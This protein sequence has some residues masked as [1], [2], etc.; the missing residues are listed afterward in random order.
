MF[1]G[2]T[3]GYPFLISLYVCVYKMT[4]PSSVRFVWS[5]RRRVLLREPGF[6]AMLSYSCSLRIAIRVIIHK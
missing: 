1:A 2:R 3:E 6:F 5:T 4:L